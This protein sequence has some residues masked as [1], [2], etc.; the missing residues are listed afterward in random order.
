M[1]KLRF[2]KTE[3][4]RWYID[5]PE[6]LA[7]GGAPESLEMVL[8]ADK[9]LE[10]LSEDRKEVTLLV[11]TQFSEFK[12]I[13]GV[14]NTL[15]RADEIPCYDGTYYKVMWNNRYIWL[16]S[17]TTFIFKDYPPVIYFQPYYENDKTDG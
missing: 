14:I 6:Y 16:C 17:V 10:E 12:N 3:E 1:R 4:G 9:L 2:Y 7:Q 15:K 13:G 11:A 8:G 5:S